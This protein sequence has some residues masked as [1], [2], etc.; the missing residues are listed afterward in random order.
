VSRSKNLVTKDKAMSKLLDLKAQHKTALDKAEAIVKASESASRLM[1]EQENKDFDAAMVEVNAI[2][3]QVERIETLNTLK[4]RTF[5][6]LLSNKSETKKK[7]VLSSEYASAF[8][9]WFKSQGRDASAAMYEGSNSAGGYAVPVTTDGTIVPL[10]P[11][12]LAIRQIARVI[13]TT[14]DLKFP[15]KAT[16][17]TAAAKAEGIGD[18]AQVF[19][20]TAPTLS[21]VT[22]SAFMAG[23]VVPV[24]WE[25]LQDVAA[26]QGFINDDIILAV[27]QYEEPKFITGSGSGE[28]QGCSTG[29]TV[30]VTKAGATGVVGAISLDDMDDL[31][32][33]LNAVY[34]PGASFLMRRSILT[35]LRK[36]Q[37]QA[38]LFDQVLTFQNGRWYYNGFPVYI[39]SAMQDQATNN[40]RPVL[41]GDFKRGFVI[42]DRGGSGISVKVLDQTRAK[43][44]MTEFLAF[45][46]TDSRVIRS[47][48]LQ[49][50]KVVTG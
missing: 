2:S 11:N 30:A 25:L 19:G 21:Q 31:E 20:G 18:G 45:R 17:A 6:E 39:S 13:E 28:P 16:H 47:E 5:G 32:G 3:A 33:S 10:A 42:G 24:S 22:L 46:R 34:L 41:F 15:V 7:G 37:R 14:N 36:L 8:W 35:F 38:N 43:E 44:G 12:E 48:A 4:A 23:D 49:A 29:A 40:N 50:I 9:T 1:T 26:A 27:Q